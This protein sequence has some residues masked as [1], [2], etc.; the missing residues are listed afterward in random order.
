VRAD[1]DEE[2][3]QVWK[4]IGTGKAPGGMP[5]GGLAVRLHYPS[6]RQVQRPEAASPLGFTIPKHTHPEAR[7]ALEHFLR[8]AQ[9]L[10]QTPLLCIHRPILDKKSSSKHKSGHLLLEGKLFTM[11][12]VTLHT[13]GGLPLPYK[14]P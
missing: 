5:G 9:D 14:F 12:F 3:K 1:T 11:C 4:K 13:K 6:R 7:E 2:H 10:D 8:Q